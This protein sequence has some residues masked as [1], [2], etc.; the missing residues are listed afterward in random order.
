MMFVGVRSLTHSVMSNSIGLLLDLIHQSMLKI[1][2]GS[3]MGQGLRP[4]W[5][6]VL[7]SGGIDPPRLRPHDGFLEVGSIFQRGPR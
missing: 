4:L 3:I 6:A 1:G 5:P 7:A 2:S